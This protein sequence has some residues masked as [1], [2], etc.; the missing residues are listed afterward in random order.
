MNASC[1]KYLFVKATIFSLLF[2]AISLFWAIG[3]PGAISWHEQNQ[4]FL[5]NSQHLVEQSQWAGGLA[6]YLAEA[7]VQ[8]FYYPTAGACLIA[9]LLTLIACS[10]ASILQQLQ[11]EQRYSSI[12]LSLLPALL[13]QVALGD[14]DTM[15]TYPMAMLITLAVAAVY[16]K[17]A[18]R[19]PRYSMALGA[20]LLALL[21]W[22]CGT[23]SL[24]FA[25]VWIA[26]AIKMSSRTIVAAAKCAGILLFALLI[27]YQ[28]RQG[29]MAQY[30]WST[31][32]HGIDYNRATLLN[33]SAPDMLWQF[34]VATTLFFVLYSLVKV[35]RPTNIALHAALLLALGLLPNSFD[36]DT[37]VLLEEQLLVRRGKWSELLQ[38]IEEW[39]AEGISSIE[40][41]IS[42]TAQNLA[43]A[44]T[45]RLPADM[46]RYPQI[47]HQG[48]LYN[49]KRDNISVLS[50]MEA[51]WQLGLTNQAM[52]SAFDMMESIPNC[53]K[54][55]RMLQRVAECNIVDG[56]YDVA[57]KYIDILKQSLYYAS[58]AQQAEK[59][60][61]NEALINAQPEWRMKRQ[62]RLSLDVLYNY[63][64]LYKFLGQLS[65]HN[66][67]N[68]M[69][70]Q[71]LLACVLLDGNMELYNEMLRLP[72]NAGFE[73]Y[74][75]GYQQYVQMMK[76]RHQTQN[77][78]ANTGASQLH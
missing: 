20:L 61:G 5:F 30:P 45:G 22:G 25:G 59:C 6:D 38:R 46:F 65:L 53:K 11:P 15:I 73:Y 3:H 19:M 57:R 12:S 39:R 63:N 10:T 68:K 49:W 16:G 33:A 75:A 51:Y 52:R 74:P 48:L 50:T 1:K 62:Q 72:E 66:S 17:L 37:Q 54:S 29:F 13:C 47:G 34:I 70:T 7:C 9:L 35:N 2:V 4:L 58:W 44:N 78:D 24:I 69:A 28:C 40:H 60:L 77:A 76:N 23:M 41:P 71:Y 31:V 55:G 32:L 27:V 43:L 67:S 8:F 56:R 26:F 64:E 18:G 21:Y 14:H 36:A 42:L